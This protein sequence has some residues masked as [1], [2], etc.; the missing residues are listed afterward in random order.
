MP[1]DWVTRILEQLCDV[2]QAAHALGI[3]HRDLKPSNLML[4]DGRPPGKEQLKVLDFGIAKILNPEETAD[5]RAPHPHR[6]SPLH[7][8]V[9]QPRTDH[10]LRGRHPQRPLLPGRHPVRDAH[11][12][13]PV[14]GPPGRL[15]ARHSRRARLLPGQSHARPATRDRERRAMGARQGPGQ[16]PRLPPTNSSKPFREPCRQNWRECTP[17]APGN[18]GRTTTN[19]PVAY[20]PWPANWPSRRQPH[21]RDPAR[22]RQSL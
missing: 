22:P 15:P 19:R 6:R 20:A 10:R 4:L 5:G 1:L 18:T 8:P 12:P 17:Q 11:R 21:G 16:A 7:A 3:V 9:R 13:P 2:L 14:Q